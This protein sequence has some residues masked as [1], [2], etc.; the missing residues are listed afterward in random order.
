MR[1][2]SQL[3]APADRR[4]PQPAQDR[5]R[6]PDGPHRA[7][8]RGR[9]GARRAEPAAERRRRRPA[10]DDHPRA[11]TGR[12]T[13]A[14]ARPGRCSTR[15]A[16]SAGQLDRHKQDIV[17]ALQALDRL[18]R[19]LNRQRDDHRRDPRR[20]ARRAAVDQHPAR[21]TW[22][23]CSRRWLAPQ[24]G[25]RP[26][27]QAVEGRRRST[28]CASSS[29][30]LSQLQASGDDFV[31]ALQRRPHLPVRRRG[32]RPR[33][34]G[35][36]QPADGRL[37]QPVI[38]LDLS[39]DDQGSLPPLPTGLPTGCRPCRRLPTSLPTSEI[40]KILGD[41]AAVPAERRHHQQGVPEGARRP[42]GAAPPDRQ[43][44]EG[45][46]RRQPG[47][48][49]AQR[50]AQPADGW[51]GLPTL[52]LPTPAA[53]RSSRRTGVGA[54]RVRRSGHAGPPC[55]SCPGSTTR[56]WSACSSPGW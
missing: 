6:H 30:V 46:E 23:G 29:P 16:P 38:K 43:V 33:P 34:A 36:P 27:D 15:S 47:L 28:P 26:R 7:E 5:R 8:P 12:C 10:A 11:R 32:R 2:S 39:L 45:Q 50:A 41:V 18:S 40:T 54:R 56:P 17:H 22:S 42:A 35:R 31:D 13:A 20:A 49:G 9:A 55:G 53:R 3:A 14:R 21:T 44:Q 51:P 1:S 19:S 4:Q 37:H 52:T 24:R 25:R 48:P